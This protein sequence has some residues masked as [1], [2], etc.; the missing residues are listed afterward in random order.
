M[1]CLDDI[2]FVGDDHMMRIVLCVFVTLIAYGCGPSHVDFLP[3]HDDGR[4]KPAVAILPFRDS[5]QACIPWE[6]SKGMTNAIYY[7]I[8]CRSDLY[9]LSQEEMEG[10]QNRIGQVDFYCAPEAIAQ[11]VCEADFVVMLELLEQKTA[12]FNDTF[13][14]P[15]CSVLK[16]PC[17][18]M[19]MMKMRIKIID[20]RPRCPRVVLQEVIAHNYLMP[21][22][23][24]CDSIEASEES[25][26]WKAQMRMS[27]IVSQRLEQVILS[28]Y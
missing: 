10:L 5:S 15:N 1:G 14:P 8:L 28:A 18:G 27:S 22:S 24:L 20:V 17:D 11:Q 3:Y 19:L 12:G 13:F 6:S 25:P 21:R 4:A 2:N 9:L 26:V 7:D 23:C 16:F